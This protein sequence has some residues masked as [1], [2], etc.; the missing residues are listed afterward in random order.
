MHARL[1]TV[2]VVAL[3]ICAA[4]C[5]DN[6][7]AGLSTRLVGPNSMHPRLVSVEPATL[8][9]EFLTGAPCRGFRPF[10][11]RFN[12]FVHADRDL[13][14]R[15]L[16]FHFDDRAGG[17]AHP[18]PIPTTVTAPT[19]PDSVPLALP[20]SAPIPIPGTLTFHGVMVAPGVNALGLAVHFD[21]GVPAEGTLSIS[22][23]TTDGDGARDVSRVSV[24]VG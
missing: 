13:V 7:G 1:F 10:R 19:I 3:S 21:C 18:L 8:R 9:P 2:A 17:R 23:E 5:D 14:L 22:V 20:S 16:R 24:R 4:R 12:L 15:G 6:G 11:T